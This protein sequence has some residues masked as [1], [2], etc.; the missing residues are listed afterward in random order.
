M[1]F[2]SLLTILGMAAI[3][4]GLRASGFW[5]MSRVAAFQ[6]LQR[7][8]RYT[9]GAIIA[10][11]VA[12][13]AFFNGTDDAIASIVVMLVMFRSQ[14]LLLSICSGILSVF[15]VRNLI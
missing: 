3:T 13:A 8:L 7:V 14:N 9:P 2:N 4:Y 5:F 10:S 1:K 12:P 6:K 11:I 15:L